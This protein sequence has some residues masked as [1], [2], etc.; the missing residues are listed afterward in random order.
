MK[1]GSYSKVSRFMTEDQST[2][3]SFLVDENAPFQL[4]PDT[5]AVAYQLSFT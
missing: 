1:N 4:Q 3:P 5:P 2:L